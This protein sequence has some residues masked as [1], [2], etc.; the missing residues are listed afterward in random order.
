MIEIHEPEL[1]A[2]IQDRMASGNFASVEDVVRS[3]LEGLPIQ[4]RKDEL[5]EPRGGL[6]RVCALV[7]GLGDDVEFSR[8]R[9]F[10]RPVELF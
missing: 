10:D 2:L 8:D 7:R 6:V 4:P 1:E 9:S 5:D 3:A